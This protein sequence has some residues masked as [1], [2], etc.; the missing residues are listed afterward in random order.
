MCDNGKVLRRSRKPKKP[1]IHYG[2]IASGNQVIKDSRVRDR[3]GQEFE[4]LCVEM[5][6]AGLMNDF[7]YIVIRGICDYADS[8]KNNA[9]QEYTALVAAA[10]VKELLSVI[11][12]IK[13]ADAERAINVISELIKVLR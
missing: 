10:Y 6:A 9:W 13:V 7:S 1:V 11:R 5:E 12:P 3:L 4:A 8:Y 2:I